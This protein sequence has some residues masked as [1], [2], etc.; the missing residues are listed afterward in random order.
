MIYFII[1]R[2]IVDSLCLSAAARRREGHRDVVV[3]LSRWNKNGVARDPRMQE[4]S[5]RVIGLSDEEEGEG[6]GR[7]I[8][9]GNVRDLKCG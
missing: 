1:S 7:G 5:S 2:I 9:R 8:K 4:P 6:G 3:A